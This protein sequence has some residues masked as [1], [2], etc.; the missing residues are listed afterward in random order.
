MVPAPKICGHI[1]E[2]GLC[3]E[4]PLTEG[5]LYCVRR[6]VDIAMSADLQP[7]DLT[8]SYE[9]WYGT[10]FKNWPNRCNQLHLYTF[11]SL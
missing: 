3:L 7:K 11:S 10:F 1:I 4:W 9:A 2:G 8:T 6:V 5:L